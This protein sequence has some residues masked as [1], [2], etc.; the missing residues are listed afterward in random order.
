MTSS[1]N[2]LGGHTGGSLSYIR[3]REKYIV[4]FTGDSTKTFQTEHEAR[5]Y[6]R[7]RSDEKEMTRNKYR[8]VEGY[9]E[10]QLYGEHIG[11]ISKKDLPLFIKCIWHA[12]KGHNRW[13]MSHSGK[14]TKGIPP[15]IFH[16]LLHPEWPE[17]D[18]INRNGLDNRRSNLRNGSNTV[19][20]KNQS[21]RSDNTSG[22]TGVCYDRSTNCWRVQW[23]EDGKRKKKSFSANKYGME[24]AKELATQ[25]R[26]QLDQRLGITN[27]YTSDCE[28]VVAECQPTP[29]IEVI[30][31]DKTNT[32][33]INGVR[34]NG[35]AW[36]ASWS[37]DGKRGSK[38]YS[39]RDY[40]DEAKE[41]AIQKR[42][43]MKP[44]RH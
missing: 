27:G 44:D 31:L 35:K 34:F 24:G 12:N 42:L 16:R 7:K 6:K 9:V 1:S 14:K 18:H 26:V 11:K 10:V 22:K 29:I 21:K 13:Y 20:V 38:T 32:S 17:I 41:L 23:P 2:W 15:Q 28:D 8:Y 36:T 3:K 43:E 33:G 39:L 30:T 40:G 19:N 25:F 4:R 37:V 5:L